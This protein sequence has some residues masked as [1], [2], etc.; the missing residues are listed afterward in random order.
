MK[1]KSMNQILRLGNIGHFMKLVPLNY[2]LNYNQC[3]GWLNVNFKQFGVLMD[4][5]TLTFNYPAIFHFY[6]VIVKGKN[7]TFMNV[8]NECGISYAL[9]NLNF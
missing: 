1:G 9:D 3:A 5:L 8:L 2:K 7:F 4:C 6:I